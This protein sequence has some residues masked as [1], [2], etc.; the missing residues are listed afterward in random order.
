MSFIYNN[1]TPFKWC[2]MNNFPFIE[3]DFDSI[4]NYQLFEKIVEYL[5]KTINT[6]NTLGLK[7]QEFA[8]YFEKLDVQEEINKKLDELVEKGELSKLMQDLFIE[9]NDNF[10]NQI[11]TISKNLNAEITQ[12]NNKVDNAI[13]GT[14]IVVNSIDEMNDTSKIYVLTTN[15][16][17]YYYNGA[18]WISGG[19]YQATQLANESISNQ[20]I[21]NNAISILNLDEDLETNF[22]K[23][24]EN[25][26]VTYNRDG[27]YESGFVL[28]E[29]D[30]Y[31][32]GSVDLEVNTIYSL[33]V[34]NIYRAI[35]AFIVDTTDNNK[36]IYSTDDGITGT[37]RRVSLTF[38]T[39]K[40]GLRIYFSKAKDSFG[41]FYQ[42][43]RPFTKITNIKLN[44]TKNKPSI[45]P[46]KEIENYYINKSTTLG[47]YPTLSTPTDPSQFEL[48]TRIYKLSNGVK[49]KVTSAD[50][51]NIL[52]MA[53]TNENGDT[54]YISDTTTPNN[55]PTPFVYEFVA[56]NNGYLLMTYGNY[57][58]PLL[59]ILETEDIMEKEKLG[60]WAIGDSIT[61][62]NYRA[63]KNYL[64][65]IQED[66]SRYYDVTINNLG[67]SGTGYK[68][69]NNTFI[70][71]ISQIVNYNFE[72]E[73]V[74][75]MGSINDIKF[76][77][78]NLGQLGDE[79]TDT[80]Y[81]SVY[82]FF[83]TLF[84]TYTGVR[85]GCISPIP[86][87][88]S[89][90]NENWN[91]YNNMLKETCKLFNVPFYDLTNQANLIPWN[92]NFRNEFFKA[93]GDGSTGE[94][95]GTHPNSKG[96]KL[97][98]SKVKEFIK[99]L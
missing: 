90:N 52:A 39:N 3:A 30:G 72:N 19:V 76:V 80:L 60:I 42:N 75:V 46:L 67:I 26:D 83:N 36:I 9:Y 99:T 78:N 45:L 68:N 31:E 86:A 15:G 92:E 29:A 91:K 18:S 95:D 96:H 32:N 64:D 27:F 6:T 38:R 53:I 70:D 43:G 8:E 21:A 16:N 93:D 10:N 66:L 28:N 20:L 74:I 4:T 34:M 37:N 65:Y 59:E 47:N 98:Y 24:Y 12:L 7:V 77:E 73:V 35:G 82:T 50:Y 62:K 81:G 25:I 13:G 11:K 71:R 1:L 23:E 85:I 57:V 49:Y 48:S 56:Q 84:N 79:T 22:I 94:V 63:S 2:I 58:T 33:L 14:P 89:L 41:T 17:W 88:T 69:G 40:T 5:N 55:I 61:N 87:Q 54:S 51:G 97:F 44:N